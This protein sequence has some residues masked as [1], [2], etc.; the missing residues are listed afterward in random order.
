MCRIVWDRFLLIK[1]DE[2]ETTQIRRQNSA[3]FP[4]VLSQPFFGT[5]FFHAPGESL[6]FLFFVSLPGLPH[7]PRHWVS[8]PL[9]VTEFAR[10][11]REHRE[12]GLYII[13]YIHTYIQ[14]HTNIHTC[15]H[16]YIP[17]TAL[18]CRGSG[19]PDRGE[20]LIRY[21]LPRGG[22]GRSIYADK[23]RAF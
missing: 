12:L 8:T 11:N 10:G 2:F 5:L 7:P 6:L 23:T 14:C 22:V 9:P 3:P 1:L 16:P 20:W 13:V 15:K 4:A 18:S 17:P 21:P 19:G